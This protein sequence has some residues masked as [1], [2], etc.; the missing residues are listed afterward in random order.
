MFNVAHFDTLCLEKRQAEK[1]ALAEAKKAAA[2]AK[3][4]QARKVCM[5]YQKGQIHDHGFQIL[6]P[7]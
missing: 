1:D 2:A 7:L 3:K 6:I 4:A 5:I